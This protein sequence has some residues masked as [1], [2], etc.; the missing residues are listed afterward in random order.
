MTPAKAHAH[1]TSVAAAK[2]FFDKEMAANGVPAKLAM[3]KKGADKAAI[4]E[5]NTSRGVLITVRKSNTSAIFLS[6]TIGRSSA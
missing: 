5:L 6:R 2:R 3:D 1:H 4:D